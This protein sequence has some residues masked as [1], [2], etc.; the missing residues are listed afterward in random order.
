MSLNGDCRAI[1]TPENIVRVCVIQRGNCRVY[2]EF[3]YTFPPRMH[4]VLNYRS[5]AL[6]V[7]PTGPTLFLV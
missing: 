4:S 3:P 2:P 6:I 5:L 7:A 1:K